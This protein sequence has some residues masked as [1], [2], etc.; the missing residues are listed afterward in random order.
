MDWNGITNIRFVGF[1]NYIKMFT[2]KNLL[3]CLTN[4]LVYTLIN[5]IYQ[6]GFGLIMAILMY[7]IVHGRNVLRALLFSPVIISTMAISQTFKKIL[8]IN[9]D[10]VVNAILVNI[11][12]VQLKTAFLANMKLTLVVVA[13]VEAYKY[14]GLYLV[15]FYSAFNA[16]DGHVVEA[17]TIDGVNGWQMY[18]YIKLP[19]ISPV[20][21][22]SIILVING[23]LKSF[24]IPFILT[25]GGP[26]YTSELMASYMYK[27]AF[28]SMD[29]GYGSALSIIIVI[30]CAIIVGLITNMTKKRKKE[31]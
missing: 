9:P 20:I 22:S 5:T 6:V 1:D 16:I 17:A 25:N 30:E 31:G 27:A 18:R 10:G 19:I 28:N 7:R 23:T 14:S 2:D 11:G 4:N 12:L 24:D 13:L 29:Y 21:I 26:G 3:Q 8:A 15:I